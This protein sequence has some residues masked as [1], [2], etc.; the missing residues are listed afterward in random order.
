[1]VDGGGGGGGGS[2]YNIILDRSCLWWQSSVIRWLAGGEQVRRGLSCPVLGPSESDHTRA[3][4][5]TRLLQIC[6]VTE[7][8][9]LGEV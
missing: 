9:R 7:A 3:Q 4:V 8:V 1:M 2:V 5:N 6:K